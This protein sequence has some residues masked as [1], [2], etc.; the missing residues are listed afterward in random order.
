VEAIMSQ[1]LHEGLISTLRPLFLLSEALELRRLMGA[2][3]KG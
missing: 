1:L 2:A 3:P